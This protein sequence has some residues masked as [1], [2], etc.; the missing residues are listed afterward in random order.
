MIDLD[1]YQFDGKSVAIIDDHEVVLEGF[2][3]YMVKK[4]AKGS[5]GILQGTASA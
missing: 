5:R 4:G 3:S 1:N 2:R